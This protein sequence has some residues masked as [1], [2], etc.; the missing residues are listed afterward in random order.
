MASFPRSSF[1]PF[2]SFSSPGSSKSLSPSLSPLD[3]N[4]DP[5]VNLFQSHLF[6]MQSK[7]GKGWKLSLGLQSFGSRRKLGREGRKEGGSGLTDY[8]DS[9]QKAK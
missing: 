9:G 2:S 5:K 7:R 6:A 4:G 1:V 8:S 3:S